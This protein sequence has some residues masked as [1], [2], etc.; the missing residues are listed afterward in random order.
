MAL[1]ALGREILLDYLVNSKSD[2]TT[3]LVG[4]RQEGQSLR[5]NVT[6][7]A[8][9]EKCSDGGRGEKWSTL[10]VEEEPQAKHAGGL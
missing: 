8:Q 2:N 4:G 6:M 3:G 1:R 10:K 9:R 5:R 7:G